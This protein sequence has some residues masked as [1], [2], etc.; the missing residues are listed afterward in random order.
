[1][2]ILIVDDDFKIREI[3]KEYASI[4]GYS[5]FEASNGKETFD[6]ISKIKLDIIILDVMLPD[7]TGFEIVKKIK[8]IPV[9]M[10]SAKSEEV[11]KLTGFENGAIDYITKPFSPKE[12]MA[13]IKVI[14]HKKNENIYKFDGVTIDKN[15][16]KIYVDD[17]EVKITLKEYELLDYF[18]KNKNILLSRESILYNVWNIDFKGT[19]RTIDTHVK[20]LRKHLNKYG[21]HIVTVRG[22]GYR[23]E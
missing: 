19:D 1:M 3:V 16:K 10:L 13:R 5:I 12:L 22:G 4:D 7:M 2:N 9:L 21:N 15:S 18:I 14:S 11:D 23:F 20:M 17:K 8:D 6:I